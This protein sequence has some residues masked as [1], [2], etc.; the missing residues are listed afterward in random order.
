MSRVPPCICEELSVVTGDLASIMLYP[1]FPPTNELVLPLGRILGMIRER[2]R[3]SKK[4]KRTRELFWGPK[5]RHQI[6]GETIDG[7]G[8]VV[9]GSGSARVVVHLP[10]A[11][12]GKC[13]TPK[14]K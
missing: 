4:T 12:A 8:P 2:E 5:D 6:R 13:E 11:A 14:N 1:P 3:E 9:S 10:R 7:R